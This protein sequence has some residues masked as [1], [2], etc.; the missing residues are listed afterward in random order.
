MLTLF[1]LSDIPGV[2][3]VILSFLQLTDIAILASRAF[4]FRENISRCI[5]S[6]ILV[7]EC[8]TEKEKLRASR[9]LKSCHNFLPCVTSD[10]RLQF[11]YISVYF[12][13]NFGDIKTLHDLMANGERGY[14]VLF[15]ICMFIYNKSTTH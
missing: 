15:L 13:W 4:N 10:T 3:S 6:L 12:N 2:F 5:R 8:C 1:D 11:V 9:L 7:E 14:L